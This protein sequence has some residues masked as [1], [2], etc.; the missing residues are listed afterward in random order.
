[1]TTCPSSI[2]KSPPSCSG[3]PYKSWP[4]SRLK[5]GQRV[6]TSSSSSSERGSRIST[7][8]R[9]FTSRCSDI[10][11]LCAKQKPT[12][13]FYE[14]AGCATG[15]ARLLSAHNWGGL[16]SLYRG[17]VC[18][19]TRLFVFLPDSI[20]IVPIAARVRQVAYICGYLDVTSKLLCGQLRR[21]PCMRTSQNPQKA[22][23]AELLFQ[24]VG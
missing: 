17:N 9:S 23:F 11:I 2:R 19:L 13:L 1:M 21:T 8:E 14:V 12:I 7:S 20:L 18:V 6:E 10:V 15:S 16:Q 4:A 24:A 3:D 22:N 5:R